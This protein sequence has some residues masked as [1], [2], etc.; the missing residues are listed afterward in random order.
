MWKTLFIFF[1]FVSFR[2]LGPH[3]TNIVY[4]LEIIYFPR[5]LIHKSYERISWVD[6][7]LLNQ[8]LFV[9]MITS[10]STISIKKEKIN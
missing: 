10:L 8:L 7:G 6:K 1:L 9:M 4:F 2:L 3:K 5:K